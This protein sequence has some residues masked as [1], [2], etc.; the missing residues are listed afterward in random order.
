M[1]NA[2]DSGAAP[3]AI[4]PAIKAVK[5]NTFLTVYAVQNAVQLYSRH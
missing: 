4:E 2:D 5:S 3:I 1:D